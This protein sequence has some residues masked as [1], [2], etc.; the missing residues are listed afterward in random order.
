MV[1]FKSLSMPGLIR[2]A[3]EDLGAAPHIVVLGSC[4]VG[5]FVVS[6]PVLSGL[7]NR[8]PDAVIGFIGSD[9]TLILSEHCLSWI[10][11]AVGMIRLLVLA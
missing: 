3:G 4:K 6:T 1:R 7:R 8:F 5:N 9:V 10:G 2:Y 11:V